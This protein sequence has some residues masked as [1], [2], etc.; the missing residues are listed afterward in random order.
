MIG[1]VLTLQSNIRMKAWLIRSAYIFSIGVFMFSF[2]IYFSVMIGVAGTSYFAPVGGIL[3]MIG[4]CCLL[5]A[6]LL[7]M[8]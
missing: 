8:N 7:K 3:L 2:S 1:L 4:W 5:R 6:A